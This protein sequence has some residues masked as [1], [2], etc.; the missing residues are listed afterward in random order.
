MG[1]SGGV[2]SA[3]AALLL[4]RSGFE[5]IGA[6]MINFSDTKSKVTGDCNY[7]ED[8]KDAQKIASIL[9]IPLKILNYEK[10]YKSEVIK[11]MFRDYS[12]GLT[13][14]PDSLCNEKIKFPYLWKEAKNLGCDYIAT[15]HYA[16][17]ERIG[18]QYTLK[19]PKDRKKDQT[20]FLYGLSSSDLEHT[21]F[22]LADLTK[23]ETRRIAKKNKFPNYNKKGTSG[24]CFVGDINMKKFLAQK[25][26]QKKGKIILANG[27]IIG[28][29][30]GTAFYT[31][32]EKIGESKGVQLIKHFGEKLYVAGKN[33]KSNILVVATKGSPILF[34]KRFIIQNPT[35]I[36]S[37]PKFPAKIK[38]RI[39]HLGKLNPATLIKKKNKI[40]CTLKN[41]ISGL[42]E[43]QSAVI[44][45]GLTALGG[46]EIRYA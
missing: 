17:I 15:G 8:K 12:M 6:F 3:V 1:L 31:I 41:P 16:K 10:E 45:T 35:W 44:Y 33:N 42:A 2:D 25:I 11:K 30:K 32:G 19:I 40:I 5:V 9:K 36:N 4:K 24:V 22:P 37:P 14:N 21:L 13:P 29:H 18:G 7:L 34:K 46:G 39:R 20:Y 38:V 26:K 28:F 27:K 23:E 43:G